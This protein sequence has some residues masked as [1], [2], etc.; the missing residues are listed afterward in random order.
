MQR[1]APCTPGP[2][3]APVQ[4]P[5]PVQTSADDWFPTPTA[6]ELELYWYAFEGTTSDAEI[7][8]ATRPSRT[9][10]FSAFTIVPGLSTTANEITPTLTADGLDIMFARNAGTMENLYEAQRA[11]RTQAF[12][13][14]AVVTSFPAATL[15][16]APWLSADGLR[17][18]FVSSRMSTGVGL[19]ETTR[20]SRTDSWTAPAALSVNLDTTN[21]DCPTTSADGLELFFS[22]NRG[23]GVTFHVYRATRA[24]LDQPFGAAALVPELSSGR[25]D[26]GLRLSNDGR[27]MYLNYD[28]VRMGTQNSQ[29]WTATRACE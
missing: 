17:L 10:E 20:V 12:G 8:H 6:D 21:E 16:T 27:T 22:S 25:D 19:F 3:A 4:L 7:V 2:F 14:P 28:S 29:M 23:D 13:A 24:A 5:G 18:M 15:D 1:D 26:I 9:T 11:S